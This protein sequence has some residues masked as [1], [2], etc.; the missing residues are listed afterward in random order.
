MA[1]LVCII[2]RN[3]KEKLQCYGIG[4]MTLGLSFKKSEKF[5]YVLQNSLMVWK[6]F[7]LGG[8]F[9]RRFGLYIV[10]IYLIIG[11]VK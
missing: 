10:F 4:N 11:D 1:F 9:P 3:L 2:L 5:W 8:Q 7:F 6:D